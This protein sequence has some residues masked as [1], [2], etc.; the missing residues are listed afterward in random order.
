MSKLFVAGLPTSYTEKDVQALFSKY[1]KVAE[2]QRKADYAFVTMESNRA[3]S[4]AL[5]ALHHSEV[6]GSQLTVEISHGAKKEND[7]CYNCGLSGHW[8]RTCTKPQRTEAR[9]DAR[10]DVRPARDAREILRDQHYARDS[11]SRHAPRDSYP[12]PRGGDMTSRGLPRYDRPRSPVGGAGAY[13]DRAGYGY[14]R[15]PV[16]EPA[17]YSARRYDSPPRAPRSPPRSASASYSASG[18]PYGGAGRYDS[19]DRRALSPPRYPAEHIPRRDRSPLPASYDRYYGNG[20]SAGVGS[21]AGYG[22]ARASALPRGADSRLDSRMDSRVDGR[23]GVDGYRSDRRTGAPGGGVGAG[24][25]GAYGGTGGD[26]Y[27]DRV[28]GGSAVA[29]VYASDRARGSS[30]DM[31][32]SRVR[33]THPHPHAH[34]HAPAHHYS[35]RVPVS[36]DRAA[37]GAGGDTYGDRPRAG[38][39]GSVGGM[40]PYGGRTGGG[41]GGR[42]SYSS[43]PRGAGAGGY[44]SYS[45]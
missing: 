40:D 45:R 8:A 21:G 35:E 30:G 37:G 27:A 9:L 17:Y 42:D 26:S 36:R 31:Y 2:T 16:Q 25:G 18:A 12:P 10:S 33:D 3:A 20:G 32:D 44:A 14:D 24:A 1:G 22:D 28:R 29:A 41:G 4:D 11:M 39:A 15:A 43:G 19:Y 5:K 38:P 34:A 13:G 7:R 6:N 23:G